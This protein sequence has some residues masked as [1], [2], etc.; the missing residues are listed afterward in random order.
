M[1]PDAVIEGQCVVA[2]SAPQ[3]DRPLR[4]VPQDV[5]PDR[6]NLLDLS[7]ADLLK[8]LNGWGEPRFRAAQIWRWIYRALTDDPDEM[9]NLPKDLRRRLSM[10]TCI[11]SLWAVDRTVASDGLT[12]K[13]LFQSAD[14][15]L[16]ETVLMRYN[17]RNTVCA[18]SQIG[19]A[20]GCPFC[21][22]GQAGF[23]RN[24]TAGEIA[25]QILHFAR[26]LRKE[27]ARV[28]NVVFMG[29]GEP[30]LN[31]CAVWQAILN[32]N[33]D[34]G[35]ALG[36]RRFT[37]STAGIAPGIGRMARKPL[38]VGLAI[39]LHAP[40]D[41]LRDRLVPVNRRF[42]L[43][44]LI[45]A[46]RAYVRRTRRQVTFE[47]ALIR[48]VNDSD[49]H[50]RRTVALLRGVLCHVNLISLNPT[51]GCDYKPSPR[52]RL[53]HFQQILVRGGIKTSVR[54]RRGTD[55][56]AGCGQLRGHYPEMGV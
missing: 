13:V 34:E 29:M 49:D 24:L 38:A 43:G 31:F 6:I 32:L 2:Q 14:G 48:D 47:Y 21:A 51:P 54:L 12:E 9:A 52:A 39:S 1:A 36:A 53:L 4:V 19:C 56:Q 40:D 27:N 45:Q 5:T 33:H 25:G 35:L 42:P 46:S 20:I 30:M 15:H 50:A 28:T 55:I 41:R 37:I 10:E 11:R 8:L 17:S 26:E 16:L 44:V 18:S 7:H 3:L 23:V 22:T